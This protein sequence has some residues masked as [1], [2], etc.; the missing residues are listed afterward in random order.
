MKKFQTIYFAPALLL[1]VA[2]L[3]RADAGAGRPDALQQRAKAKAENVPEIPYE[4]VPNFLKLPPNL[5]LG[6]GIG[7]ATNSKGH[8]FVYTRSGATRLFEFDAKGNYSARNRRGALRV[9]VRTRRPRRPAR[10]HL[11]GRRRQQHGDQVQP[12]RARRD[13]AG[14][15]AGI[16][17]GS[18]AD[19]RF[20][21]AAPPPSRTRSIA[22]PTSPGIRPATSS[23][24]TATATRASR[25]TT[26]TDKFIASVGTRGSALGQLNLPHTMAADAKGNIYV[27]DRSN[28]RIQVFDNDLKPLRKSTTRWARPGP[29]A[30]RSVRI[31]I[32]TVPIPIPTTTIPKFPL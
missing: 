29:S 10:Q 25:N 24:R 22:P 13:G 14:P 20:R 3:I 31:S 6:E 4:S 12:R 30:S 17:G 7:V 15:P 23:S 1:F 21:R 32:S 28:I 26:R 18:S 27:G 11:G 19:R 2:I 8:V 5:Y 16:G 9:R